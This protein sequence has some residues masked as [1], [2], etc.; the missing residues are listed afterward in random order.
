[1]TSGTRGEASKPTA[2]GILAELGADQVLA[3]LHRAAPA[4]ASVAWEAPAPLGARPALPPFPVDALPGWLADMVAAVAEFTQTPAD[5]PA[6]IALAALSA[7]AGGRAVV[8]VRGSWR[9]PVNLY[10]VVVMPP[11]SRKSA[12]FAAMTAP[13]LDA[14]RHL[15]EATRPRVVEAEL[16]RKVAQRAAATAANTPTPEGRAA[17][18]ADATDAA[19]Q[20]ESITVPALPRLVADDVTSEV[21]ASLLAEQGGRLAVLSAEGGIFATLAG[22]YSNGTPSLEV[23]LKGHA[24]DMLRVDRKGRLAEHID[25]PPSPSA[26]R[27]NPNCSATS[28]ACPVF[29]AVGCSPGFS[30]PFRLTPSALAGPATLGRSPQPSPM[31]MPRTCTPW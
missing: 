31:C 9:E 14:E 15:V 26:W 10:A 23:F 8:E 13:L 4:G 7:T 17:A 20:A 30:T 22:R 16:A 5:L 27:S 6:V 2:E 18:L 19:V 25:H 3:D 1:L 28:P 29:A 21:A 12:V 11:G 24:G